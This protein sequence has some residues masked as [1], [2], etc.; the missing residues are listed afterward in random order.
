MGNL[1]N[2]E[3]LEKF[4]KDNFNEDNFEI[5]WHNSFYVTLK[6]YQ[7]DKLELCTINPYMII[8]AI[9]GQYYLTYR[10]DKHFK[11]GQENWII[12]NDDNNLL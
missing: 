10:L 1:K 9:N 12:V 7:G 3:L 8:T 6:D 4:I 5:N 2:R 11:T